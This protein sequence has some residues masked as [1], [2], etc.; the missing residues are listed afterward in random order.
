MS[1]ELGNHFIILLELQLAIKV[2]HLVDVVTVVYYLSL[3]TLLVVEL[4]RV[5]VVD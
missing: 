5:V 1:L 4:V 2:D 3:G